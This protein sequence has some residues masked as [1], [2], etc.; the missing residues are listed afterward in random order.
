MK[1]QNYVI[2]VS[3]CSALLLCGCATDPARTEA[4]SDTPE[5]LRPS[6]GETLAFTLKAR[7]VQ[8]YECQARKNDAAQFEWT[9]KAPEADLFDRAGRKVGTHYKGPTWKSTD[10]SSVVGEKPRPYVKDTNAVPWLLMRA[11]QN[12]G[13]GVFSKVTSIQRL[14]TVG[15]KAPTGGCD[16]TTAGKEI[17]VPYTATYYFYVAKP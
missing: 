16:S 6:K 2:L 10:G 8:I 4:L 11:K 14:H 3:A 15:G 17:R 9:F 5:I 13:T 1:I 7:G 12:E